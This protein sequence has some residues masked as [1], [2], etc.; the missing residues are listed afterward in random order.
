MRPVTQKLYAFFEV[1]TKGK[2]EK[3][4]A[5]K[6]RDFSDGLPSI[7]EVK[8][9]EDEK[10]PKIF[11]SKQTSTTVSLDT[12]W[13]AEKSERPEEVTFR[14]KESVS[15]IVQIRKSLSLPTNPEIEKMYF[16]RTS[17]KFGTVESSGSLGD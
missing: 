3:R 7:S 12:N 14:A 11:I 10:T 9:E 16:Q 6:S 1:E 8:E 13:S 17:E 5:G 15:T 4:A 2:V